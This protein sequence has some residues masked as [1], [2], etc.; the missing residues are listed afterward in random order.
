MRQASH[1]ALCSSDAHLSWV[2]AAPRGRPGTYV[3]W[4]RHPVEEVG[5]TTANQMDRVLGRGPYP[6]RSHP[7]SITTLL[8]VHQGGEH[9]CNKHFLSTST[10]CC[11]QH[12]VATPIPD[13]ETEAQPWPRLKRTELAPMPASCLQSQSSG[14]GT[15][16]ALWHSLNHPAPQLSSLSN[17][18]NL[19]H[20][21]KSPT[22]ELGEMSSVP[23]SATHHLGKRNHISE[24]HGP[25]L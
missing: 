21:I 13:E 6:L 5:A 22:W 1:M 8:P 18:S 20:L 11:H 9:R 24:P 19:I 7:P 10:M 4:E 25:H 12:T 16:G 23:C 2:E 3:G 14:R 17:S 15:C